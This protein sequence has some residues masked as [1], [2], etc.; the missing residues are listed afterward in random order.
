MWH[1]LEKGEIGLHAEIQGKLAYVHTLNSISCYR[2]Y[3]QNTVPDFN[4][5][6]WNWYFIIFWEFNNA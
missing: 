1:G 2:P 3:Q 4:I 6:N 5:R